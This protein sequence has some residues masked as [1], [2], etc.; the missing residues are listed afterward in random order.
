M[1]QV[2]HPR[3]SVPALARPQRS[4]WIAAL[5]A[6][7]AGA[8]V[9]LI[10]ALDNGSSG[11][12]A[13]L[14]L[15]PRPVT[16][17]GPHQLVGPNEGRFPA[18]A[19]A[20]SPQVSSAPNESAIAASLGSVSPQV[21]GTPDESHVAASLGVTAHDVSGAPNESH[22]AASVGGGSTSL[23][24]ESRPAA[25]VKRGDFGGRLQPSR[26]R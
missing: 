23:P 26:G 2:T 16:A 7:A 25:S 6:L 11:R 24:Q 22:I 1:S 18:S 12:V 19:R 10:I 4:L 13:Q 5:L 21:A 15:G 14:N 3:I 17:V 9:V 20:V 8:V